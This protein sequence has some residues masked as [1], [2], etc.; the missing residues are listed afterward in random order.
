MVHYRVYARNTLEYIDGG[1]VKLFEQFS[2]LSTGS[3]LPMEA[4][5][6]E[7]LYAYYSKI[8]N[9]S[10]VQS[11]SRRPS[12]KRYRSFTINKTSQTCF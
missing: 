5:G 2:H 3:H 7:E 9:T 6:Y 11:I 4:P 10:K 1:V 8:A 12:L